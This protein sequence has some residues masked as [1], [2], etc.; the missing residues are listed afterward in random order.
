MVVKIINSKEKNMKNCEFFSREKK[1]PPD[2]V[3]GLKNPYIFQF[4]NG[5]T[6]T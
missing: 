1:T 6:L 3:D 5:K 4:V 2:R